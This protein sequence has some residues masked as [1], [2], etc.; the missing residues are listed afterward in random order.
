MRKSLIFTN[1]LLIRE[2]YDLIECSSSELYHFTKK[3]VAKLI[4]DGKE[5]WITRSDSFSDD[6]EIT[7]GSEILIAALEERQ[8]IATEKK[9]KLAR[10]LGEYKIDLRSSYIFCLTKNR[11]NSYLERKYGVGVIEFDSSFPDI[12][13]GSRHALPEEGGYKLFY[14]DDLYVMHEGKVKYDK[15]EQ[16]D[17]V[18]KIIDAVIEFID[19]G[20]PLQERGHIQGLL[21]LAIA[22]CKKPEYSKEEEYRIVF[23]PNSPKDHGIFESYDEPAR[24]HVKLL[25][26]GG[27]L[28]FMRLP[29]NAN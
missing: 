1:S 21:V 7:Y 10:V 9:E 13:I 24:V 4:V 2:A 17:F 15:T 28:E 11:K 12:L 22:L 20:S 18:N 5:L 27:D 19:N 29:N 25:L 8:D 23:I 16:L 14:L 3:D 26:P 6:S